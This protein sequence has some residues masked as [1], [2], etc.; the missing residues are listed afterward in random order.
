MPSSLLVIGC[1]VMA[2]DY[3]NHRAV[4]ETQHGL[5]DISLLLAP[6]S[7]LMDDYGS[8]VCHIPDQTRQPDEPTVQ[9]ESSC[10]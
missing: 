9:S 4:T 6:K 2:I 7:V 1:W 10:S 8:L 3:S 5:M